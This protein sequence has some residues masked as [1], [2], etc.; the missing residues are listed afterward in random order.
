MHS[1]ISDGGPAAGDGGHPAADVAAREPRR[2]RE[3][4]DSSAPRVVA[5]EVTRSCNLACAH[6]RAAAGSGPYEGELSTDECLALVAQIAAAGRP[7]LILTGG[8]PLLRPDIFTIAQAATDAGLR[9]VMAPNGTLVT[10]ASAGRMKAAGIARISVSI[11]FPDPVAHDRFRGC[12]GAFD[13]ALRGIRAAQDAGIEIQINSTITRLNVELLPRLLAL[14]EELGAVSFHPFLLVPTGRGRELAEQELDPDDYERTLNWLYDAQQTSGLF[15]KPTDVPHYWRVMRQRARAEGRKLEVHRHSH[16]GMDTLSRGCLAGVGFCF[17]SHV[18]DVQPCGY[19][20][21]LAGNVREQPFA[22]IWRGS[23][24]FAELRDLDAL[25]GKCG[26]C[27]YKRVCGGCRAR[28]Y[29]RTGDYL[30]EEPYCS[31]QPR[32]RAPVG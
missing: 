12:P 6:C 18:G 26:A 9:T 1:G 10:A 5:W 22:D 24:L 4:L 31:Y 14:A 16:G 19:F 21:K 3:A 17:V 15:F 27:E 11:D 2:R 32:G 20:D 8:E 13:S 25:K 30:A 29:E 28:A 23:P 7:I